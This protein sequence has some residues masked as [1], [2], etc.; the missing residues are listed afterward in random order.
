MAWHSRAPGFLAATAAAC[1]GLSH[2]SVVAITTDVVPVALTRTAILAA[3]VMI[4][5]SLR[6]LLV[7]R[8]VVA[9]YRASGHWDLLDGCLWEARRSMICFASVAISV[10][11]LHACDVR[12]PVHDRLVPAA[13]AG[14]FTWVCSSGLRMNSLMFKLLLHKDGAPPAT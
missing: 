5:R 12:L 8:A 14:G 7:G 1:A 3:F 10:L 11:I 2:A 4:A 13:L 6:L 9:R